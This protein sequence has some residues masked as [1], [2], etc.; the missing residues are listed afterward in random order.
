MS[1]SIVILKTGEKLITDLQE[2]FDGDDENKKGICLIL[3]HPYEL[4]LVPVEEPEDGMDL[5]I[6]FS[7]W[8]PYAIDTEFRVPYDSVMAIGNPDPTLAEAFEK[9]IEIVQEVLTDTT[10]NFSLQ[11]QDIESVLQEI[12]NTPPTK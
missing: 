2:A 6:E 12:K 10:T 5:R 11:Q 9:K 7:K 1:T 3:R 8:C 4:S